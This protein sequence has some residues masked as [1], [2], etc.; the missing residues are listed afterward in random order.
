[1]PISPFI[2]KNN[3]QHEIVEPSLSPWY[4]PKPFIFAEPL[5]IHDVTFLDE[6]S[7]WTCREQHVDKM[8]KQ[9]YLEIDPK[10]LQ[11]LIPRAK[12]H[13]HISRLFGLVYSL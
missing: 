13:F 3:F 8:Q 2:K 6:R 11:V 9:Y 1:M 5:N 7:W 12:C 10:H 4:V